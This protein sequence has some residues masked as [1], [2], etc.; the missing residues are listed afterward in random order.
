V[1]A[2]GKADFVAMGRKLLADPDLPN[3]LAAG[4]LDEIRPSIYQYRCIGNI[5]IRTPAR[6][7]VNPATGREDD[8]ALEPTRSPRHVLVAGGGPA[9]LSGSVVA[10]TITGGDPSRS[11]ASPWPGALPPVRSVLSAM[12]T[13]LPRAEPRCPRLTD[14][15]AARHRPRWM[16]RQ[17]D[18]LGLEGSCDSR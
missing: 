10:S 15:R 8:P 6:C 9:G 5:A 12:P 3:T 11:T 1:L 2:D 13:S 16:S 4:R 18:A 7:V 17:S 14:A